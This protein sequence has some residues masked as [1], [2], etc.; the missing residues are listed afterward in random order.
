LKNL[1]FYSFKVSLDF[2]LYMMYNEI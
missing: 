2:F 1:F